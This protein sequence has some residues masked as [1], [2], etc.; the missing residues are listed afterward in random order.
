MNSRGK[1]SVAICLCLL[2]TIIASAQTTATIAPA[3]V[4]RVSEEVEIPLKFT[5]AELAK[6]PHR[7][8]KAKG[9][10]GK[11]AE[12]AGHGARYQTRAITFIEAAYSA[13]IQ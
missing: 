13:S 6:L 8:L 5:A 2:P 10:D 1:V 12:L 7:T 3:V 9:H 4:L 11:E